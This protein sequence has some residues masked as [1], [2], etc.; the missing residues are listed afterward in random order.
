MDKTWTALVDKATGSIHYSTGFDTEAE[1]AVYFGLLVIQAEL[2][3][4]GLG[5]GPG[6]WFAYWG[7]T[8][9]GASD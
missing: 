1:A 3:N 2:N 8:E 7:V 5:M 6:E 4:A 9:Y